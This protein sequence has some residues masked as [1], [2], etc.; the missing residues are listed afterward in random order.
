MAT[1]AIVPDDT[2]TPPTPRR[3]KAAKWSFAGLLNEVQRYLWRYGTSTDIETDPID[4]LRQAY[5]A[6]DSQE[7]A[8][9]KEQEDDVDRL[10]HLTAENAKL[11]AELAAANA[12]L[13][14]WWKG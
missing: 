9:E 11:K 13:P 1:L 6:L 3:L 12:K 5:E 2:T 7:K 14:P 4:L 10:T 8:F